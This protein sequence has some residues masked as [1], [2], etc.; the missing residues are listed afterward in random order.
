M[1]TIWRLQTRTDNETEGESR[2]EVADFCHA[3]KVLAMGWSLNN[4]QI[5]WDVEHSYVKKEDADKIRA[6]RIRIKNW[7]QY[8][9]VIKTYGMYKGKVSNNVKRLY[10]E[11][12]VD[13][14][15]WMRRRGKYYLG[16]VMEDS[17]WQYVSDE[18]A[19]QMDTA[20]RRTHIEWHEAGDEADVP[21][22]VATAF[23][24]GNTFQRIHAES[25]KEYSMLLYNDLCK[26]EHY[27]GVKIKPSKDDSKLEA[28]ARVF[29]SLLSTDDCED[30]LCAW[31]YDKKRYIVIP[32]TNKK[33]TPLYE[34]VLK[35]PQNGDS[36]YIQVKKG[37]ENLAAEKYKHLNGEV[38]L[39]TTEGV[40]D[41]SGGNG[42]TTEVDP[43]ELYQAVKDGELNY[44]L[45]DSITRWRKYMESHMD[46]TV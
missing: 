18:E 25:I 44:I 10:K 41:M 16:R 40:V 39:L 17:Q 26:K 2:V 19:M 31:L 37:K 34:C 23:I 28:E 27:V 11:I 7:E 12:Q 33:S 21:G 14:L 24:Q 6:E 3:Q 5:E 32:S 13:D 43:E 8:E 20:N 36:I 30:L 22:A 1:T 38:Y 42:R 45:S 9:N 4:P 29:Y 35:N 46:K 15:V